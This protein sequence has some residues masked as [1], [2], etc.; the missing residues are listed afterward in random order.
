MIIFIVN[1]FKGKKT[2]AFYLLCRPFVSSTCVIKMTKMFGCWVDVV[3]FLSDFGQGQLTR[4]AEDTK[5]LFM[6]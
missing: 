3:C 4:R 5:V 6:Y 1:F 2:F